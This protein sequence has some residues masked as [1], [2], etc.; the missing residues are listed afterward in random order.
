MGHRV[1]AVVQSLNSNN[2][3]VRG[4]LHPDIPVYVSEICASNG[5]ELAVLAGFS[6]IH[7][8]NIW[9]E[10]YFLS[11]A[12]RCKLKYIATLHG[13]YEV[14]EVRRDQVEK[15]Y[16]K[17]EWT[18]LAER[19]L[20]KFKQ[21]G[22]DTSNIVQIPNGFARRLSDAPVTRTALG[23]S[24]K[25]LVF[26]FAAR[27]H[28]EKGWLQA[29]SAFQKLWKEL[30]GQI[31]LLMA[32]E[33]PEADLICERFT[34]IPDIKV[35]GFRSDVDDLLELADVMLLPTRFSGELMPLTLI[36][37]ILAAVPII[38]T[39]VGQIK[40]MLFTSSGSVGVVI[41]ADSDDKVF[42]ENLYVQMKNFVEGRLDVNREAFEILQDRFSME[43]CIGRYL[44][45]YGL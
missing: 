16:S 2:S 36:Q 4:W 13:S 24:A 45:L 14:S 11:E 33:G 21:F 28:P 23:V 35:L 42:V 30:G 3:F 43:K 20:E 29:A 26:L 12:W 10:F 44:E 27:S 41:P 1:S 34:A 18:Y 15:F 38:S 32:G 19:N 25:A 40:D 5:P 39:D 9:S 17:V 7:S 8:H 6:I 22:F 31:T 37:S